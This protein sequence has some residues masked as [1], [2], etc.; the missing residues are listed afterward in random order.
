M[1]AVSRDGGRTWS[2]SAN[3]TE[4]GHAGNPPPGQSQ[5]E[6][7]ITVAERVTYENG[8]GYLHLEYELDLNACDCIPPTEGCTNNPI[9]YQRV[10]VDSIPALP[11]V[12][13]TF[14]ILHADSTGM[15]GR[16]HPL[17]AEDHHQI[18]TPGLFTLYQNDPNPFNPTTTIRFD[19]SRSAA[20]TLKVFNLLGEEVATLHDHAPLNAGVHT[21][22]FDGSQLA[23]GVYVVQLTVNDMRTEQ[24]MVLIR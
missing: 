21:V 15:P 16:V 24:K 18:P 13:W 17:T 8:R 1:A 5:S 11:L 12:D 7:D 9:I 14:P 4:T 19:L 6:R 10:P 22:T 20:V 3:L 2:V 23:S